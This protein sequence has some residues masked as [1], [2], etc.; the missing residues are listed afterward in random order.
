M[1][2]FNSS[3]GSLVDVCL[4]EIGS[5]LEVFAF[6]LLLLDFLVIGY[7]INSQFFFIFSCFGS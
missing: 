6:Q 1:D 2:L 7:I 5:R 3:S 4:N